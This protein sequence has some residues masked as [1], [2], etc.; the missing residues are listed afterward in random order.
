MTLEKEKLVKFF[1]QER[2]DSY[3]NYEE[4]EANIALI[5]N[6][7]SNLCV[8]ELTIRNIISNI[9]ITNATMV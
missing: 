2:L 4:H 7:S 5:G 1:S 6:I 8:L 9:A 3:T